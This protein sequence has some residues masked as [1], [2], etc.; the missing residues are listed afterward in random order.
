MAKFD[1]RNFINISNRKKEIPFMYP[2][3]KVIMCISKEIGPVYPKYP[4]NI[5]ISA[6]LRID[7]TL[8]KRIDPEEDILGTG[9]NEIDFY[10]FS[11]YNKYKP[12]SKMNPSLLRYFSNDYERTIESRFQDLCRVYL[13]KVMEHYHLYD[14]IL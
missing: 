6:N 2:N 5:P 12:K 7:F 13:K 10:V 8:K 9:W 14:T 4:C 3:Y 1:I 11:S